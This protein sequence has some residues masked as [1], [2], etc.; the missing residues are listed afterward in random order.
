MHVSLW[1]NKMFIFMFVYDSFINFQFISV[2]SLKFLVSF[3]LGIF[4]KFPT[5]SSQGKFLEIFRPFATLVTTT[6]PC[7][8]LVTS[9][10]ILL[11]CFYSHK[12]FVRSYFFHKSLWI[13]NHKHF[14]LVVIQCHIFSSFDQLRSRSCV[15]IPPWADQVW[16]KAGV[17]FRYFL[18]YL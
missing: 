8:D 18:T 12:G 6:L 1:S 3:K 7:A 11:S 2:N 10:G 5:R 9:E 13:N 4:P 15:G 17:V 16:C 14:L